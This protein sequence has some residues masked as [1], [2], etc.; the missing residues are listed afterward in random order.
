MGPVVEAGKV[1]VASLMV[2]GIVEID[3]RSME[4]RVVAFN[5]DN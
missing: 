3:L 1:R 4:M 5:D 2:G